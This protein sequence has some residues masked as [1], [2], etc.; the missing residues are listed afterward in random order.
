MPGI[1]AEG[2]HF[3]SFKVFYLKKNKPFN[4]NV[5]KK[6]INSKY[7]SARPQGQGGGERKGDPSPLPWGKFFGGKPKCSNNCLMKRESD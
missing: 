4:D 1:A 6:I 2:N 3:L 5:N 7:L